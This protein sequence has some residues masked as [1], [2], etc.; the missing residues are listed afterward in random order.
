[1]NYIINHTTNFCKRYFLS[2]SF[3]NG[4]HGSVST[5]QFTQE[6]Y[7][8][9]TDGAAVF[10]GGDCSPG[11]RTGALRAWSNAAPRPPRPYPPDAISCAHLSLSKQ[12]KLHVHL[13]K[14]HRHCM[15]ACIV[16]W[17]NLVIAHVYI[18]TELTCIASVKML[19]YVNKSTVSSH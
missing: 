11:L 15:A 8:T 5:I 2:A 1:M 19:Y 16:S 9:C 13:T 10:W 4:T 6:V 14:Y 18:K 17:N 3:I 12:T 7:R